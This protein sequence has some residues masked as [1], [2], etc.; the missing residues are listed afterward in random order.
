MPS[1]FSFA[2]T[3]PVNKGL[4]A[5]VSPLYPE[6]IALLNQFRQSEAAKAVSDRATRLEN[7]D[8]L[9]R[10]AIDPEG[11]S[12]H[13]ITATSKAYSDIAKRYSSEVESSADPMMKEGYRKELR[14]VNVLG[15]RYKVAGEMES[16]IV[17]GLKKGGTYEGF[18]DE[19]LTRDALIAERE[20]A[21]SENRVPDFSGIADDVANFSSAKLQTGFNESLNLKFEE[22]LREIGISGGDETAVQLKNFIKADIWERNDD[23]SYYYEEDDRV[24]KSAPTE[25]FL[26]NVRN[27]GDYFKVI[28]RDA[29]ARNMKWQEL[30]YQRF[31][32]TNDV[33][34][35]E[36][37]ISAT[38]KP[39]D[40]A[41]GI[42]R[43]N[44]SEFYTKVY[45]AMAPGSK[46]AKTMMSALSGG[47]VTYTQDGSKIN[48]KVSKTFLDSLD[49]TQML[50]IANKQGIDIGE[51]GQDEDALRELMQKQVKTG[52]IDFDIDLDEDYRSGIM[53]MITLSK[54]KYNINQLNA[55]FG[56]SQALPNVRYN[57]KSASKTRSILDPDP[58]SPVN[59]GF[60]VVEEN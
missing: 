58:D 35:T 15:N 14:D 59:F 11:L 46:A 56:A 40:K 31:L 36:K 48:V 6:K 20:L 45:N 12:D 19:D 54:R 38:D 53:E 16:N 10:K 25:E 42:E 52:F 22:D 28:Q 1:I 29:K 13:E 39:V 32:A 47:G 34:K 30:A 60:P 3:T 17:L 51:V 7:F 37:L 55:M 43:Q 50:L 49:L 18:L 41:G 26:E 5:T 44:A 4:A 2:P 33:S 21:E 8:Y 23:G 24:L 9:E 57:K 27:S